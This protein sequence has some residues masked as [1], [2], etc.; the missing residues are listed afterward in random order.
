MHLNPMKKQQPRREWA[1]RRLL[2]AAPL[3]AFCL[4]LSPVSAQQSE[5]TA[6]SPQMREYLLN[7][8]MLPNGRIV[9]RTQKRGLVP[10]NPILERRIAASP[11]K[12]VAW[13]Q[14]MKQ[15][16][17]NTP[18]VND[19]FKA[20]QQ[21]DRMPA[22]L[23]RG[24]FGRPLIPLS[25]GSQIMA[26]GPRGNIATSVDRSW[27]S[28]GPFD[29]TAEPNL[30]A[31]LGPG[32]IA[33]RVNGGA[34]DALG[35]VYLA[36]A[37]GGVWKFKANPAFDKTNPFDPT[38][39][40]LLVDAIN[41]DD[42]TAPTSRDPSP[43]QLTDTSFPTLQTSCVAID[44][45]NSSVLY[46]GMGDYN[47]GG[48]DSITYVGTSRIPS[49][50]S[51]NVAYSNG[52]MKSVNGG[53]TWANLGNG[54]VILPIT[55][56]VSSVPKPINKQV[57]R[58]TYSIFAVATTTPLDPRPSHYLRHV[59][60]L[61]TGASAGQ[62]RTIIDYDPTKRLFTVS[63][64][65]STV[66]FEGDQTT[67]ADQVEIDPYD[68]IMEATA[69][70]AI[71]IDPDDTMRVVAASGRGVPVSTA[72][73]PK[74]GCLWYST[75]GG[76]DFYRPVQRLVDPVTK[77]VVDIP[78]PI[79]D[80]SSV[81]ISQRDSNGK[82]TYYATLVGSGVY[83]SFDKGEVWAKMDVP[84]VYNANPSGQSNGPIELG[85]RVATSKKAGSAN[86]VYVFEGSG[87]YADGRVFKTLNGSQGPDVLA[88]QPGWV[89]IT[90]DFPR[91]QGTANNL[92]P[93]C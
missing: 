53:K 9:P 72:L 86:I 52:I 67:P 55:G 80:W 57:G 56:G 74:S 30:Q 73:V 26:A 22:A 83:R 40:R 77:K 16:P 41:L 21:R 38:N 11:A 46:V 45:K 60:K 10:L 35:N 68:Q 64:A 76:N 61:S 54:R 66:P 75:N 3:L 20:L 81:D 7:H 31:T 18:Q 92:P 50:Q 6:L 14:R 32:K 13:R 29:Y 19:Y 37:S 17:F 89:D 58:F 27:E 88:S 44:P 69:V 1:M 82:R 87:G 42:P 34:V 23:V 93:V 39:P 62:F 15:Y 51:N 25:G 49:R 12:S 85:L 2:V 71:A 90:G 65:F 43:K 5:Q 70:N 47:L 4:P 8:T 63:P 79:G 78:L 48:S 84:L 59:I 91:V 28:V 36:T 24:T 33:G